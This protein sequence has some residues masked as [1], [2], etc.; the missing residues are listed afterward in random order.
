MSN[1]LHVC[2]FARPES[3]F[4]HNRYFGE[5]W[6]GRKKSILH[7]TAF[8]FTITPLCATLKYY[9]IIRYGSQFLQMIPLCRRNFANASMPPRVTC[10]DPELKTLLIFRILIT[11]SLPFLRGTVFLFGFYYYIC[12]FSVVLLCDGN[13]NEIITKLLRNV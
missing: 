10:F 13:L 4:R 3:S 11:N 1:L 7:W 8:N 6:S 2:S 9:V 5:K 12:V